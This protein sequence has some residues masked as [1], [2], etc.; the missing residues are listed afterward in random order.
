MRLRLPLLATAVLG[1]AAVGGTAG[2]APAPD[3]NGLQYKDAKGDAALPS[4]EAPMLDVIQGFLTAKGSE[5]TYHLQVAD[6]STTA[7][8]PYLTL[9]WYLMWNAADEERFVEASY[10]PESGMTYAYGIIDPVTGSFSTDGEVEV[11]GNYTEGPDG[12]FSIVIPQEFGKTGDT[13]STPHAD[14]RG[15][16]GTDT[17]GGIVSQADEATGKTLKL[18]DCAAAPAPT[19]PATPAPGGDTPAPADQ[20]V[21]QFSLVGSAGKAKT[22][23]KK[24]KLALKIKS[25]GPVTGL[26]AK[27][28]KG[29]K[30]VGTGKLAKLDGT[31]KVTVKLKSKKL[32]KGSYKLNVAA[33]DASGRNAG[34]TLPVKLK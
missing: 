30:V 17:T 33:K 25:S 9:N 11:S 24:R 4:G 31:A 23:S 3:C 19:T 29:K 12:S 5:A 34:A 26:T 18:T 6:L 16:L 8:P 2:A 22:A 10:S 20:P 28:I 15:G 13:F 27:L 32:K 7:P 1:L 14:A 21:V